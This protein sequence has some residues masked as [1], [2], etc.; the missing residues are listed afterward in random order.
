MKFI[1]ASL[2]ASCAEKA[3]GGGDFAYVHL[4]RD[5]GKG[6]DIIIGVGHFI[7][8]KLFVFLANDVV[9]ALINKKIV[10]E[11]GFLVIDGHASLEAA[12]HRFDIAVAMVNADD[13]RF[14]GINEFV[15]EVLPKRGYTL[16]WGGNSPSHYLVLDT[17]NG[18]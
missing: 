5:G 12:V 4:P 15:R 3:S 8:D 9:L 10:L 7:C 2:A 17:K 6:E 14:I 18:P 1:A 13:N 16:Q 11:S